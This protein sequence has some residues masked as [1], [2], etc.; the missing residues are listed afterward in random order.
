MSKSSFVISRQS[1]AQRIMRLR[2][3]YIQSP[4]IS[5]STS[6]PQSTNNINIVSVTESTTTAPVNE[7]ATTVPTETQSID[8]TGTESDNAPMA[9][10]VNRDLPVV[11]TVSHRFYPAPSRFFNVDF[12]DD[13]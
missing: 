4:P 13:D 8:P 2:R 5:V 7:T 6:G 12:L 1:V 3:R 10:E 11:C 9:N